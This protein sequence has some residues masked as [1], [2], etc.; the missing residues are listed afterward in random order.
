MTDEGDTEPEPSDGSGWTTRRTVILAVIAAAAVLTGFFVWGATKYSNAQGE[1]DDVAAIRRVAGD[2]GASALTY[3]YRD[4]VPFRRRMQA[5]ATGTFKKQLGD[6]LAGLETLIASAKSVSEGTVK[7]IYV[8][9]VDG[10]TSSAVVVVEARA[11]NGDAAART[12][13]AAY[14]ELQL[15]KTGGHWLIDGV[16][17]LDLGQGSA[18]SPLPGATTTTAVPSK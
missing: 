5:H 15:V 2:F 6:G 9:D 1:L 8:A 7:E 13:P 11:R 3:D 17:S 14:I 10:T 4:L 16:S 18:A 12:L